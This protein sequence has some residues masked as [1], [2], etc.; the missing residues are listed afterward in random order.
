MVC[1][2]CGAALRPGARFC[3][4]CGARQS[5]DADAIAAGAAPVATLAPDQPAQSD[6]QPSDVMDQNDPMRM[7]RPPR[8]PRVGVVGAA[9]LPPAPPVP[10]TGILAA[11]DIASLG[12]DGYTSPDATL[13]AQHPAPTVPTPNQPAAPQSPIAY[14]P[15]ASAPSAPSASQPAAPSAQGMSSGSAPAAPGAP[16]ASQGDDAWADEETAEYSTIIPPQS[17]QDDTSANAS[18]PGPMPSAST[19][20]SPIPTDAMPWPLPLN[21]IVG[22]RYRVEEVIATEQG[23]GAEAENTYRVVDLQ[24]YE[25]CWSCDREYGP[26]AAP[27]RFCAD[28]GADMLSRDYR[29]TE[30]RLASGATADEADTQAEDVA[31]YAAQIDQ[32]RGASNPANPAEQTNA[33]APATSS[34]SADAADPS[35]VRTFTQGARVY[36]V[37][38]QIASAPPAFPWGAHVLA[39]GASDV[40]LSRAGDANED[41]FGVFTLNLAHESRIQPLALCI[42]A[43]GLGGHA[44]G[45]D[46]SRLVTRVIVEHVLGQVGLPFTAPLGTS[47]PPEEALGAVL[48]EAVQIANEALYEANQEAEADMG[49][50]LVAALISGETAYVVNVGDSRC[51]ALAPAPEEPVRRLTTDHSLVEQLILGGLVK[52]E[53]R[54]THPNRNQIFRS[55]G[56]EATVEVDLF[57]QK[58]QPGMRLLLCSDGLW[59]MTHDDELA[60]ILHETPNPRAACQALMASANAHGGEDNITAVVVEVGA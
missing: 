37:A 43:D 32:M 40:G 8:T 53:D 33:S 21:I 35:T 42:V 19:P 3:N 39:A 6:D 60:K 46:A 57:T 13:P 59:E 29:L 55:L 41:S 49:S 36:R 23:N 12:A 48:Q 11:P 30:R 4:N 20:S 1:S 14:P 58:L 22:G 51:Y 47:A 50:T 5:L 45:Q 7:K 16:T 34:P 54:Y 9:T 52:P 2:Q 15:A 18:A 56:G 24:G 26:D 44:N 25:H 10:A 31:T 28:C 38:Q 17:A 27:E